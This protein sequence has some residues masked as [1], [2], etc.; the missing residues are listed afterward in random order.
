M[1]EAAGSLSSVGMSCEPVASCAEAIN[2][3]LLETKELLVRGRRFSRES[4][5]KVFDSFQKTN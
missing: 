5:K 3:D 2:S 4:M 1:P